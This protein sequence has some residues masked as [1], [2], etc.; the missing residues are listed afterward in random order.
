MVT[1]DEEWIKVGWKIIFIHWKLTTNP[2]QN[3][4]SVLVVLAL[5]G[6]T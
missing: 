2:L 4:D 6:Y 5:S 1:G 3:E